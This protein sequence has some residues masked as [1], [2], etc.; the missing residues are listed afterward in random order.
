MTAKIKMEQCQVGGCVNPAEY[1]LFRTLN[2]KKEWLHVCRLH[3]KNIG[4]ENMRR[5]G[6]RYE[7]I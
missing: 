1:G 3:E 6:G 4:D 7:Q 2:G 5:T